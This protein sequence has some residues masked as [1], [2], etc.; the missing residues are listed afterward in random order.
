MLRDAHNRIIR[1]L[2]ISLTDRCNFRCFYCLPNGEPPLARKETILT[3]EEIAYLSDIFVGLGI[4]KIRLTGGEP[5]LRKGI[6]S[7]VEQLTKLKPQ[8]QD[9]ALTTNGHEFPRHAE[10]LKTA[11]L[12]RV[13]ISLDSLDRDRFIDITG[14]DALD[15]VYAAID[16]AK[17]YG[18]EPVKINA[19]LVRGR[20]DDEMVEFAR[21]AREYDVAMRFI[22]FMPLDSG[23]DWSREIVVPG[24]E[25]HDT[26]NAVYP[27]KLK[28]SSRGSET[29]WKYEFADGAKG[30]IGIIA[31]VTEMF[32]GACS[33]IRL[34]AD[35]QIRTCLFS[36][37][38]HNLRDFVR[39][40]ASRD[41]IVGFIENAVIKKEPRHYINDAEF[42]QPSRTMSF[43]GG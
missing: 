36:T 37:K 13:T 41:E 43:I 23:H 35:G 27:L 33:R 24:K 34:T 40:G 28:E 39:S 19:V 9:L 11:G 31:P 2:R 3:F 25:I 29:A 20:N 18:F 15:K 26:I 6:V 4:E 5:M 7:L 8:L 16:A 14:V 22:E 1:D 12:D 38:E 42:I 30:E 21:F 17:K 32:C 10:A